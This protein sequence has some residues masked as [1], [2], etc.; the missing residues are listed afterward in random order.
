MVHMINECERMA[1][2]DKVDT[3]SSFMLRMVNNVMRRGLKICEDA[4]EVANGFGWTPKQFLVAQLLPGIV[5]GKVQKEG[6]DVFMHA[7][8]VYP[9]FEVADEFILVLETTRRVL[10][11][12]AQI[13]QK[14]L[15]GIIKVKS[16]HTSNGERSL[17]HAV[18]R[19]DCLSRG[20]VYSGTGIS[21]LEAMKS[22]SSGVGHTYSDSKMWSKEDV[23][24]WLGRYVVKVDDRVACWFVGRPRWT[25]SS[26][27][28]F[29][30]SAEIFSCSPSTLF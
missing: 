19:A 16:K 7:Y 9:S 5:F 27:S 22:N 14:K 2:Y 1:K 12:E 3:L 15:A 18:F 24:S 13:L 6:L 23:L 4:L 30:L 10:I 28:V 11:D 17:F 25:S 29:A 21:M 8:E 20:V 26:A